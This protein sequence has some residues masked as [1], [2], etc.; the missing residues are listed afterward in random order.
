MR[1]RIST[2]PR[3]HL[4]EL[5]ALPS[6][7]PEGDSGGTTPGESAMAIHAAG[8]LRRMGTDVT[9][10]EIEPGRP[11]VVAVFEPAR[12]ARATVAFGPHLDTVGVAGMNVPPV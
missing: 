3:L 2:D 9:L 12:T 6:V 7:S 11:N 10:T 8:V 5:V 1:M 4:A